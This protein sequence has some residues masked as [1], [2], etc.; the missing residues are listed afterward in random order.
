M[1]SEK[2]PL[3][4][5]LRNMR[6]NAGLG[7]R[8]VAERMKVVRS[9]LSRR[10]TSMRIDDHTIHWLRSYAMACG[11]DLVITLTIGERVIEL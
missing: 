9:A 6:K 8:D 1:P 5:T 3:D 2:Q 11:G 7:Q 4:P 10:E